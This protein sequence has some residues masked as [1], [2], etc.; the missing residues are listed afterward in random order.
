MG[1]EKHDIL[2]PDWEKAKLHGQAV[3]VGFFDH[4]KGG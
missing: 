3:S 4:S 2:K 1:H